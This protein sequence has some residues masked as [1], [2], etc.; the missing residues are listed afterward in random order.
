MT[1]W[2]NNFIGLPFEDRGRDR[3]GADCWGL[4]TVI[5]REE[6]SI[7][8]PDYLGYGSVEEHGEI[9]SLI[10]GAEQ[11]PVWVPVSGSAV[12]FDLAVFRRGKLPTHLGVV[13]RHGLMIHMAARDCA[14]LEDYRTGKWGNRLAGHY[15]HV[16]MISAGARG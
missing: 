2:C 6:L 11:T 12:S 13:V 10:V 14:K 4:T 1:H 15:R 5:F 8:L 9:A 7:S 16:E 3:S